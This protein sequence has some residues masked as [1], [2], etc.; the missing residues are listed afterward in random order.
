MS[1]HPQQQPVIMH[2]IQIVIRLHALS[3]PSTTNSWGVHRAEGGMHLSLIYFKF[4][5]RQEL[6]TLWCITYCSWRYVGKISN[7]TVIRVSSGINRIV[8]LSKETGGEQ[9]TV[10]TGRQMT[11]ISYSPHTLFTHRSSCVS[12]LQNQPTDLRGWQRGFISCSAGWYSDMTKISDH[13]LVLN[14]FHLFPNLG[15]PSS[16]PDQMD[17]FFS[18]T[19]SGL[20]TNFL[21][22]HYN[23]H[24]R[25][26]LCAMNILITRCSQIY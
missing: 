22:Y 15:N 7:R 26:F 2:I 3:T 4:S 20:R 11:H 16:L 23:F 18:P 5:A 8:S 1:P 25:L 24:F 14:Q 12:P 9:E 10:T 13:T 6:C 21:E 19:S 17:N